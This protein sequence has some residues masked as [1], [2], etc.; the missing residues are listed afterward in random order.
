MQ[1]KLYTAAELAEL[2]KVRKATVYDWVHYG[3]I[4]YAKVGGLRFSEADIRAFVEANRRPAKHRRRPAV[5]GTR[6][7]SC[8][9]PA[10]TLRIIEAARREVLQSSS[11]GSCAERRNA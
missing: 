4:S 1:D 7:R 10:D 9:V 6:R 3:K 5:P 8:R 2:L 11:G